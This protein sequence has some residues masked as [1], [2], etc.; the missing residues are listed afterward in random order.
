VCLFKV[1]SGYFRLVDVKS[2]NVNLYQNRSV[3]VRL[4][5]VISREFRLFRMS[6]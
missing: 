6:V 5:Q 2:F 4:V 1:R 3:Y